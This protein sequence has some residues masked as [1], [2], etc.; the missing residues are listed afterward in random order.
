[1]TVVT[2]THASGL[3]A[4]ERSL[5]LIH[6]EMLR[7]A[8]DDAGQVRLS[9]LNVVA[10]CI[11]DS[12]AD[13]AAETLGA[14]GARHPARVIVVRAH[15]ETQEEAIE[16]DVSLQRTAVGD[17]DVYT[18][19]MRL[20]VKGQP[21]FHLASIVTPLL[22]PDIPTDLWVV[23]APRLAQAFSDDAVAMC[24]RIIV[25]SSAY[26]EP[27]E[28]LHLIAAEIARRG[29]EAISLA[30]I[31]WE[32]TRMWRE[33]VAQAFDAAS[34][35]WLRHR[36]SVRMECEGDT[37]P[38]QAW[39]LAGWFA[40]RLNWPKGAEPVTIDLKPRDDG[41][42]RLCRLAIHIERHQAQCDVTVGSHDGV[43]DVS[44]D[45]GGSTV[46]RTVPD[47]PLDM[48][49]LISRLLDDS[50]VD[51]VYPQ[52]VTRAAMLAK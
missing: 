31:G 48:T 12:D 25:D 49:S 50:R 26:P 46:H 2:T 4:C 3:Q 52:A 13:L 27:A 9:V 7:S 8:A 34:V 10:G 1:M 18:E 16:A 20:V 43:V 21:A 36:G 38:G 22:I 28:P 30:D 15:P 33:L 32:R 37:V 35:D 51:R 11:A 42:R 44:S 6:E 5:D 23:G 14:I 39:L 17:Y 45:A 29:E 47:R 19:M 24:D 41:E 40:S